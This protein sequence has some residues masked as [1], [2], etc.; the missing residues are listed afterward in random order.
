MN[1]EIKT[2]VEWFKVNK[3]CLN[4]K[5]TNFMIFCAKNKRYENNEN[6]IL[7][8]NITVEQV[9]STK[10]L[11]VYI[12]DKLNWNVHIDYIS[13]KIS[14]NIGVITRARKVLDQKTLVSLYYTFIYPYLNYCC[15]V[16][17][18]APSKYLSKLHILQKRILRILCGKPRLSPSLNLFTSLKILPILELNKLKLATFCYKSMSQMLPS[19]FQDFFTHVSDIHSHNTRSSGNLYLQTPRTDYTLNTVR[20]QAPLMWNSLSSEL[21]ASGTIQTFKRNTSLHLLKLYEMKN[22][23]I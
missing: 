12:D 5:K 19:I 16:W 3:L 10:F 9:N 20:F 6:K 23:S 4:I 13:K 2:V 11:G 7:V 15:S 18:L 22:D 21:C 8:D 14:K 17:G 1:Q